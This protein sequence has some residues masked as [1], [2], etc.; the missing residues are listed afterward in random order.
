MLRIVRLQALNVAIVG[1]ERIIRELSRIKGCK[2][3]KGHGKNVAEW[4]HAFEEVLKQKL[5]WMK[6][7]SDVFKS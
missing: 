5:S 4:G 6:G 7:T 1:V 3:N 2:Q